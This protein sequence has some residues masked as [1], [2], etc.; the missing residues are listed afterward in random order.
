MSMKVS[1]RLSVPVIIATFI[2]LTG[3]IYIFCSTSTPWQAKEMY[4]RIVILFPYLSNTYWKNSVKMHVYINCLLLHNLT[5][6]Q[7]VCSCHPSRNITMMESH[8]IH[9]T[10]VQVTGDNL[11]L[12]SLFGFME[13]VA[14]Y[15][16]SSCLCSS[17]V[18]W[19]WFWCCT[20]YSYA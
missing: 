18:L 20:N 14:R 5:N 9:G 4:A 6:A 1:Y 3:Y 17:C 16:C 13:S 11:G 8:L 7:N 15:S 2:R 10:V 19:R 12:R